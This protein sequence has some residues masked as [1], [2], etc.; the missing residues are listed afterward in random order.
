MA[1]LR[2]VRRHTIHEHLRRQLDVGEGALALEL[3]AI[4][5]RGSGA[6]SPARAAVLGDVLVPIDGGEVVPHGITWIVAFWDGGR[7]DVGVWQRRDHVLGARLREPDRAPLGA[8][9]DGGLRLRNRRLHCLLALLLRLGLEVRNPPV[10]LM[11][12]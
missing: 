6:V 12:D 1:A 10:A 4:R 8:D 11:L 3:D 5:E 7:V 2:M 9:A